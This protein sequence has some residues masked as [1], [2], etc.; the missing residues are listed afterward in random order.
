MSDP[1]ALPPL[2]ASV[3][4]REQITAFPPIWTRQARRDR[5]LRL[6]VPNAGKLRELVGELV[7]GAYGCDCW[8]KQLFF[9][10]SDELEILRARSTD[11]PHL[12]ARGL[13]DVAVTGSDYVFESG[14]DLVEIADLALITGRICLLTPSGELPQPTPDR[15][16]CI[17]TQYPRHCALLC[18]TLGLGAEIHSVSGAGE[19]YPQIR[20]SDASVDC[21]V[22]GRTARENGLRIARVIRPVTTGVYVRAAEAG[23]PAMASYRGITERLVEVLENG[24]ARDDRS[25]AL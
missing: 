14:E 4:T 13:V 17:S 11:L 2:M 3:T 20:F 23:L 12:V 1:R 24:S 10:V 15:P 18:D 6:G 25:L 7:Q 21:V 16:V 19:L 8:S 5:K 22:T 9:A